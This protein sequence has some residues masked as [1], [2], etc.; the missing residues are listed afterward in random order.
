MSVVLSVWTKCT[1]AASDAA[2]SESRYVDGT[3]IRTNERTA[4]RYIT[5]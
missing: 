2:H 4:D 1:L 5:L 3:E